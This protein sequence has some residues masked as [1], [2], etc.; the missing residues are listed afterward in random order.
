MTFGKK[1][2]PKSAKMTLM[3]HFYSPCTL[4]T[5]SPDCSGIGVSGVRGGVLP[6]RGQDSPPPLLRSHPLSHLPHQAGR[7]RAYPATGFP[8]GN[9]SFRHIFNMN[10]TYFQEH[11]F[12]FLE[13]LQ[14]KLFLKND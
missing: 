11:I 2:I 9:Y 8:F 10:N 13:P 3:T 4:Y 7:G 1:E 12:A 14:Q 5:I 6:A